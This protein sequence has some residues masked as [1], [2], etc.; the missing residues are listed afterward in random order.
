MAVEPEVAWSTPKPGMKWS[1]LLVVASI[2]T[3]VTADQVLPS[4]VVEY[5]MSL[6]GQPERNRQPCQATWTLPLASISAEGRPSPS[7]RL[8]ATADEETLATRTVEPQE[9][10]PLVEVKERIELPLVENG[11]TTVPFGCTS[12]WPPRP[13]SVPEGLTGADQVAGPSCEV[14]MITLRQ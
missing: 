12:G 4:V 10:P 7:R 5:T 9:L 3:R 2:G 14:D 13:E 8:P 11:T 6:A 1:T